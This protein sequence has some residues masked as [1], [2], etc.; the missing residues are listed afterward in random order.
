MKNSQGDLVK[1]FQISS[2]NSNNH[3]PAQWTVKKEAWN[4]FFRAMKSYKKNSEL[5]KGK[6]N[7]HEYKNKNGKFMLTFTNHSIEDVML[8]FPKIMKL[9]VKK[10]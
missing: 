7:M 4:S 1:Q 5:F 2:D 6:P 8:G 9:E 3:L 10:D